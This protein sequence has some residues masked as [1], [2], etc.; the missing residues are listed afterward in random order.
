MQRSQLSKV[1][2]AVL[3]A[4]LAGTAHAEGW[5]KLRIDASSESAFEKSV[6]SLQ[7]RLTPGRRAAFE[8]SLLDILAEGTRRAEEQQGEYT[9]ADYRRQLDGLGYEQVV[10]LMDPSGEKAKRYRAEYAPTRGAGG[11]GASMASSPWTS[12]TGGPPPVEGGVYRG[13]S[14]SIDRQTH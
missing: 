4:V 5:R 10:R 11:G 6:A 3:A 12:P 8:R 7:D 2:F 13:A 14:R 1:L 9:Q